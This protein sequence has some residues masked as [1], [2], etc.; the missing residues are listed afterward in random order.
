VNDI[1]ELDRVLNEKEWG[2]VENKV[3]DSFISV[4]FDCEASRISIG[5]GKAKLS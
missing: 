5:V 2:V 1:R 3:A 4:K